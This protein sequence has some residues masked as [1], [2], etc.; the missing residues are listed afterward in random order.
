MTLTA[1]IFGGAGYVGGELSRLLLF[2]PDV[3]VKQITSASQTGRFVY[4]H[5]S[6]SGLHS[7]L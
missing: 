6:R 4:S 5:D 1:S 2:H 7:L 3:S